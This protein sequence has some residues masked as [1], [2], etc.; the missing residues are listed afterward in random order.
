MIHGVAG[1]SRRDRR[2]SAAASSRTWL[3]ERVGKITSTSWSSAASASSS[4]CE[5]VVV[6]A[7]KKNAVFAGRRRDE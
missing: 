3:A 1:E 5:L 2:T 7:K 4:V 6:V